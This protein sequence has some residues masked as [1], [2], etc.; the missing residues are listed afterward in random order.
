ML[1]L[2]SNW[3]ESTGEERMEHGRVR[4]SQAGL[5][6]AT[7]ETTMVRGRGFGIVKG[8][9]E[10]KQVPPKQRPPQPPP[11]A[12]DP[13]RTQVPP[14]DRPPTPKAPPRKRR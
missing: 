13:S 10:V 7:T 6:I 14:K 1:R 9:V 5:R 12:G 4:N 8:Q 11:P 3:V 2:P